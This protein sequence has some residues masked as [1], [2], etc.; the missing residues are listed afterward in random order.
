MAYRYKS[1]G[2]NAMKVIGI[3][4]AVLAI[5]AFAFCAIVCIWSSVEGLT[6]GGVLESWFPKPVEEV[7]ENVVEPTAHLIFKM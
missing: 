4:L 2:P 5:A 6:F 7:V 3:I 1:K